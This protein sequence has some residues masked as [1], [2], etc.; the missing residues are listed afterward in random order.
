VT[1][2]TCSIAASIMSSGRTAHSVF[3]IPVK[4]NDSSMYNFS[5][6]SGI[7]DLL[8]RVALIIWDKVAMTKR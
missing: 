8:H 1:I 2:T 3:K 7:A 6:Q 5:K 4:I